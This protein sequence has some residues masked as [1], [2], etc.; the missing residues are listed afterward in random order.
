MAKDKIII[1]FNSVK[2]YAMDLKSKS[3]SFN[4]DL[5][6]NGNLTTSFSK[7]IGSGLVPNYFSDYSTHVEK[8]KA[9]ANN[10][11]EGIMKYHTNLADIEGYARMKDEV[12]ETSPTNVNS[13]D[14]NY[15]PDKIVISTGGN[16]TVEEGNE[17]TTPIEVRVPREKI[18]DSGYGKL[19]IYVTLPELNVVLANILSS[20]KIT[21]ADL[22]SGNYNPAMTDIIT[23][24]PNLSVLIST[25]AQMDPLVLQEY[26]KEL[27][28]YS[29]Q[30]PLYPNVE[31]F[32][33]YV[34]KDE[35]IPYSALLTETKYANEIRDSLL[36]HKDSLIVLNDLALTSDKEIQAELNNI[37]YETNTPANKIDPITKEMLKDYLTVVAQEN[38]IS[39]KEM[40]TDEKYS[41]LSKKAL[42]S[43]VNKILYGE[44]T[45]IPFAEIVKDVQP[46][47]DEKGTT[48]EEVLEGNENE[49]LTNIIE[50]TEDSKVVEIIENM[51][52]EALQ[53]YIE[54]VIDNKHPTIIEKPV[55]KEIIKTIVINKEIIKNQ[56]PIKNNIED[57]T[58]EM[59]IEEELK[60]PIEEDFKDDNLEEKPVIIDD[61]VKEILKDP[62]YAPKI[63]ETVKNN[64]SLGW[65]VLLPIAG[66]G[67]IPLYSVLKNKKPK[68]DN[69]EIVYYNTEPKITK[70][71]INEDFSNFAI[72]NG[73]TEEDLLNGMNFEALT[74]YLSKL[75]SL[76]SVL[77]ILST[78]KDD[79]L[80]TY[81]Y[82]L[83]N[84]KYEHIWSK[85]SMIL[86]VI[87]N[88]LSETGD[89][90]G[91]DIETLLS[92]T[93]YVVWVKS[94]IVDLSQSYQKFEED[95]K[96]SGG[97]VTFINNIL[98]KTII[99][100]EE[101]LKLLKSYLETNS[102]N[103]NLNLTSY[104]EKNSDNENK[105]KIFSIINFGDGHNSY[106]LGFENLIEMLNSDKINT[107]GNNQNNNR[108]IETSGYLDLLFN[109][110]EDQIYKVIDKIMKRYNIN[111]ENLFDESREDVLDILVEKAPNI[112]V[113]LTLLLN[114][115]SFKLQK[116]LYKINKKEQNKFLLFLFKY[117]TYLAKS[118]NTTIDALLTS[119][120]YKD[121]IK[122][123][124]I[125]LKTSV[126]KLYA[127]SKK[128]DD[129]LNDEINNLLFTEDPSVFGIDKITT[130][131]LKD[132][133]SSSADKM[134]IGLNALLDI[135]SIKTLRKFMETLIGNII[136]LNFNNETEG[137][138]IKKQMPQTNVQ[139]INSKNETSNIIKD[140]RSNFSQNIFPDLK[141]KLIKYISMLSK[142]INLS[143]DEYLDSKE[144][145]NFININ[146]ENSNLVS[147]LYN[148]LL[149][150]CDTSFEINSKLE[151]LA[152]KNNLKVEELL[153]IKGTNF[154]VESIIK[155]KNV[156]YT[157]EVLINL[158]NESYVKIIKELNLIKQNTNL[159]EIFVYIEEH[160]KRPIQKSMEEYLNE[161]SNLKNVWMLLLK[162]LIMLLIILYL[163]NREEVL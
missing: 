92:N 128:D 31:L 144:F 48:I 135:K 46:I 51:D 99:I 162:L 40:L 103:E 100:L 107:D 81:L 50:E 17:E 148:N 7:L 87:F 29:A 4:S 3:E 125:N 118:E 35:G 75:D 157:L 102:K 36:K 60:E 11:S 21:L 152:N 93:N 161:N 117:L 131:L 38:D 114:F 19:P 53:D 140:I 1:D 155:E 136:Y 28:S 141:D 84:L 124:L 154:I 90:Q 32:L 64:S 63:K 26:L 105:L 57:T 34:A 16:V 80:Q 27:S 123:S 146:F 70:I 126:I 42:E 59:P 56:P 112:V 145:A 83:Y 132:Y 109:S 138:S 69:E 62:K 66:L 37:I 122:D 23:Q 113:L 68:D 89:K 20:F 55:I 153:S 52:D 88:V 143:T 156:L 24:S 120:N 41:D 139:T 47:L 71:I 94:S 73:L 12:E 65:L 134:K 163:S 77:N 22:L 95:I 58:N 129:S 74:M 72:S 106:S 133:L 121:L 149:D 159:K 79:L 10:L 101:H 98:N 116:Y 104:L 67:A 2:S 13:K 43:F 160:L 147:L 151:E 97:F 110:T 15:N 39:L 158:K 86:K 115:N 9:F 127:L 76:Q 6:N 137:D 111:K 49:T 44:D 25:I 96:F 150:N 142:D 61:T 108:I 14:P 119:E 130:Y 82:E 91:L 5:N 54:E 30:P 85:N 45:D 18:L 78:I 8:I 33:K